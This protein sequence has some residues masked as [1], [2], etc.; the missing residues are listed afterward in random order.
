MALRKSGEM[1]AGP[2]QRDVAVPRVVVD[3]AEGRGIRPV[4][5][6]ELGGLTFELGTGAARSFVKWAPAGSGIDLPGEAARMAWLRPF[7][8]VP[9]ILTMGEDVAG[10]WLVTAPLRGASA[11]ADRWTRDPAIAVAA[12]GAGLRYLHDHAPVRTCPFSWSARDRLTV[13]R[14]RIADGTT[15]PGAWHET[16]QHLTLDDALSILDDVPA[17]EELVVCHGDACAPNSI[18]DGGTWSG[19]VD[20]GSL[21][22][23]DR[24]A[25][26]AIATWST[27]W[28]YGPGWEQSLLDAYGVTGDRVRTEYYRLLWDLS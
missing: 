4:W 12:I 27:R 21:G 3:L 28:N 19:H 16:H 20:L 15:H 24:W 25:D 2:P 26:L 22:T 18:I 14:Q 13:A 1:I 7:S 8:L 10:S 11:V 23:A 5:M 6:N 9:D 17:V